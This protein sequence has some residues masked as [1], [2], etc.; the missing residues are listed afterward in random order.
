MQLESDK[1]DSLVLHLEHF[2]RLR[3]APLPAHVP[4]LLVVLRPAAHPIL[5]PLL[6][7]DAVV[8]DEEALR[9]DLLLDREQPRVCDHTT[10]GSATD[11]HGRK[12][13]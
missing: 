10:A 4:V 3:V 12:W 8:A 7:S 11:A 6:R 5:G 1:I 13:L 9:V 2:H